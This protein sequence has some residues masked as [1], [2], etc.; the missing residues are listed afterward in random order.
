[1]EVFKTRKVPPYELINEASTPGGISIESL[2]ALET[3]AFKAGIMDA[4]DSAI[5]RAAELSRPVK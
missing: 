5:N 3:Y 2:Y 1:M 4:I